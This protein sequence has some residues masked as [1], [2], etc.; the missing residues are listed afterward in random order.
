MRKR[1]SEFMQESRDLTL[2]RSILQAFIVKESQST[3]LAKA[4]QTKL[5]N[6]QALVASQQWDTPLADDVVAAYAK[7]ILKPG[8][9]WG[10][11]PELHAAALH[12]GVAF[13]SARGPA[14]TVIGVQL[15][16][17]CDHSSVWYCK[18]L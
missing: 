1:L 3:S 7:T 17:G 18:S 12:F 13:S 4:R 8:V 11:E 9:A 6:V 14:P 2:R 10:G 15:A 5:E 16:M